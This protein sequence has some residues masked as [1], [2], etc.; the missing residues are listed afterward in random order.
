MKINPLTIATKTA[1]ALA[2]TS[3]GI[4]S[5]L[6]GLRHG[7]K[8]AIEESA[9]ADVQNEVGNSLL[10]Y[11]SP[12]YNEAK[13]IS[14]KY[15]PADFYKILGSIKGFFKGVTEGF[16]NNGLTIAFAALSLFAKH[17]PVK[18]IA[19]AGLVSSAVANLITNGTNMFEKKDFLD[20]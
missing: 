17:K 3:I 10:N 14:A 1:G 15:F 18:I 20:K 19:L 8:L 12:K 13:K 7:D 2:L 4:E 5:C 11:P 6:M 16:I 9:R